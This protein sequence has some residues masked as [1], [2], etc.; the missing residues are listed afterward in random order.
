M[1]KVFSENPEPVKRELRAYIE[2]RERLSMN[3]YDWRSCTHLL[4]NYGGLSIYDIDTEQRY[5][6]DDKE[7]HFVKGDG[8]ALIGNPFHPYGTSTHHEYYCIHDDFFD[9]ILETDHNSD[10]ILKL[11]HKEPKFSSIYVKISDS[12]SEKN[13]MSE[14]VTPRHQLQS[15]RQKKVHDYSQKSINDLKLVILGLATIGLAT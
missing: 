7:I 13:S 5:F 10:I 3:K 15:K 14:I 2:Y 11:I 9:R 6:V 4:A 12:R 1:E 8:Y